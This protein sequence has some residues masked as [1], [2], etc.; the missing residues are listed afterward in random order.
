[1]LLEAT[2]PAFRRIPNLFEIVTMEYWK[3]NFD[4]KITEDIY[5]VKEEYV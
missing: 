4:F 3:K 5:K 2:K 1:M